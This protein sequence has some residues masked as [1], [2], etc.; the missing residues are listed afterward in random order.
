MATL[1]GPHATIGYEL[2]QA[3]KG[4]TVVAD[5]CAEVWLVREATSFP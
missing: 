4:A 3:R 5:L 2:R 1:V